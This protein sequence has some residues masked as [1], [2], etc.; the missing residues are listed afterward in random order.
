[1]SKE[2]GVSSAKGTV[3][4]VLLETALELIVTCRTSAA[5]ALNTALHPPIQWVPGTGFENHHSHPSTAQVKNAWSYNINS[6]A[7]VRERSIPTE[8][9]P[10]VGE[11]S[12][13]F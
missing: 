8:R 12:A 3:L 4:L 13:N 6:V 2:D 9:P 1:V 5:T 10:I 7:L 11:I